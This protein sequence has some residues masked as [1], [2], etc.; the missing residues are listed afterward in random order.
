MNCCFNLIQHPEDAASF[1]EL[2]NVYNIPLQILTYDKRRAQNVAY[3]LLDKLTNLG[4]LELNDFA[5]VAENFY[6]AERD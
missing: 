5:E 6:G 1:L 4:Y 3:S 2:C